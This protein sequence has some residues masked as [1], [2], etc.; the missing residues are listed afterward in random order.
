MPKRTPAA[1]PRKSLGERIHHHIHYEYGLSGEEWEARLPPADLDA[2]RRGACAI[3]GIS[4]PGEGRRPGIDHRHAVAPPRGMA[5]AK[6]LGLEGPPRAALCAGCNAGLGHFG[7][8][9]ARLDSAAA[10]LR[11]WQAQLA[12]LPPWQFAPPPAHPS[13]R[14]GTKGGA[15]ARRKRG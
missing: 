11:R 12:S 10:Y 7:D 13:H 4:F 5:R 8:D 9:P 3:C 6:Y 2:W 1:R 14:F 15:R